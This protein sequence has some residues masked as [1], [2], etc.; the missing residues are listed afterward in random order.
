MKIFGHIKLLSCALALFV[1][2][3]T[4]H[5]GASSSPQEAQIEPKYLNPP[6]GNFCCFRYFPNSGAGPLKI[7]VSYLDDGR[8]CIFALKDRRLLSHEQKEIFRSLKERLST[9]SNATDDEKNRAKKQIAQIYTDSAYLNAQ[10]PQHLL[11]VNVIL[12]D[13]ADLSELQLLGKACR[14]KSLK[15]TMPL[16]THKSTLED[17]AFLS[18]LTPNIQLKEMCNQRVN[19]LKCCGD[20]LPVKMY[21]VPLLNGLNNLRY[22]DLSHSNIEKK[23]AQALAPALAPLINL[24][25]LDLCGNYM[26]SDCVLV[27]APS[28]ALLT[29]LKYLN[30]WGNYTSSDCVL[31]L[32]PI[33][34]LLTNLKYLSLDLHPRNEVGVLALATTRA[35]LV[36]L[37]H[38]DLA[39]AYFKSPGMS[40][41]APALAKLTNLKYLNLNHSHLE[42]EGAQFLAQALCHLTKLKEVILGMNHFNSDGVLALAP[43][44]AKLT[45]LKYLYM[46]D[47]NIDVGT[48]EYIRKTLS[49]IDGLQLDLP[50]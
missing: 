2:L 31:V 15:N 14:V 50:N 20:A 24:E 38:L 27:L 17:S 28:L 33:L 42:L 3:N 10:Y 16:I 7:I 40:I 35:S 9:N 8:N 34:A 13:V 41:L 30:L 37:E 11:H 25:H 32:A 29:N 26:S 49:H 45:N 39:D 36:N 43:A 19:I 48:A 22:L 4:V 12:N 18:M 5:G 1:L 21:L 6:K 23:S 46:G 47:N 44:L